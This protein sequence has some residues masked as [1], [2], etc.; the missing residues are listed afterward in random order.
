MAASKKVELT[1]KNCE[2]QYITMPS[3]NPNFCTYECYTRFRNTPL[4][5][6]EKKTCTTCKTEKFS[7]EFG[8]SQKSRDGITTRCKECKRKSNREW[9]KNADKE[10][11]DSLVEYRKNKMRVERK[12]LI[13][14]YGGM[15]VCC[16]ESEE[17]FMTVD[18]I[19]NDGYIDRKV[20]KMAGGHVFYARLRNLGYPKDKYQLLCFNCNCAKGFFGECP[21]KGVKNVS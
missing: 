21:H 15:C 1:C 10:Y 8:R 7:E 17:N 9:Y 2:T 13:E 19:D 18:H 20:Q 16:G 3:R 5:T 4:P 12:M 11:K 14:A 6:P